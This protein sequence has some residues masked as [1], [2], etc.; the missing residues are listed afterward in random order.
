M[1]FFP[2]VSWA[3]LSPPQIIS[4]IPPGALETL[5]LENTAH[6]QCLSAK[7]AGQDPE[8][9]RAEKLKQLESGAERIWE[10]S[11]YET[12][13]LTAAKLGRVRIEALPGK[14]LE[15]TF[16]DKDDQRV[17]L[18]PESANSDWGY[19]N[20]FQFTVSAVQGEWLQLPKGT[21]GRPAWMNLKKDWKTEDVPQPEALETDRVY[22]SPLGDIVFLEFSKSEFSYRAENENDLPCGEEPKEIPPERLKTSKKPLEV[23][24]DSTGRLKA[25]IKYA[26]GC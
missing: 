12:P 18:K 15:A 21:L 24:F 6:N 16:I 4:L 17:G 25:W 7:K 2:A 11:L 20:Y 5:E 1:V 9:C 8:K 23:L 22:T 19:G 3:H 14:G 26:R 10:I 13:D